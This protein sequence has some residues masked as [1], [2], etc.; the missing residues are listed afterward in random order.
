MIDEKIAIGMLRGVIATLEQLATTGNGAARPAI[1][2][3]VASDVDLDSQFGDEIIKFTPRDWTGDTFKGARM[4][5][6]SPAF[7]DRLADSFAYFA[8]KN[9]RDG[10]KDDK[11]RPKSF[12]DRRSEARARGWAVRLRHGPK[13]A[14]PT[15]AMGAVGREMVKADEI[16]GPAR[17]D[18]PF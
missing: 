14:N 17:E 10:A 1:G 11:G 3:P 15:A 4:S 16:F 8:Q 13:P 12:Y 18:D 9:D 6:C 7:L 2:G 5:Q